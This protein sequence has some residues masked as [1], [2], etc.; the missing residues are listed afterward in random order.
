VKRI[1][2]RQIFAADS[3]RT[4]QNTANVLE[5]DLLKEKEPR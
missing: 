3:T 2:A 4:I 5:C 1:D